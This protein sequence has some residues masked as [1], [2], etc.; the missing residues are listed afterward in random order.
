MMNERNKNPINGQSESHDQQTLTN[1]AQKLADSIEQALDQA[2]SEGGKWKQEFEKLWG[3]KVFIQCAPQPLRVALV[4]TC[5]VEEFDD[6]VHQIALRVNLTEVQ[7]AAS[8]WSAI[9]TR[10]HRLTA[11]LQCLKNIRDWLSTIDASEQNGEL[12][13]LF[14]GSTGSMLDDTGFEVFIYD[15][16]NEHNWLSN[17]DGHIANCDTEIEWV[18][19]AWLE[20]LE[21][22]A[23]ELLENRARFLKRHLRFANFY[24]DDRGN[25][26]WSHV[27]LYPRL[28]GVWRYQLHQGRL[29][30]VLDF[31][32]EIPLAPL[33]TPYDPP[34][35]KWN[36]RFSVQLSDQDFCAPKGT[37][38]IRAALD[39]LPVF[40]PADHVTPEIPETADLDFNVDA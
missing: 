40:R 38:K 33:L 11:N 24:Q 5:D 36:S 3:C 18:L 27:D 8:V 32:D 6:E 26:T 1:E 30:V 2:D 19:A 13:D 34:A 22:N 37:M 35:V 29:L 15:P 12:R 23:K 20:K 17:P 9:D 16:L 21:Y 7:D 31:V 14:P 39:L 4:V 10:V 25:R 28:E